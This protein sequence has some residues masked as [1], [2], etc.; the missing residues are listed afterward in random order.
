MI[1]DLNTIL[2]DT[3]VLYTKTQN[4][5]WNVVGETFYSLHGLFEEHY[6][7]LAEAVDEIAERIRTC[8]ET[9]PSTLKEFLALTS[10]EE[11]QYQIPANAMVKDLVG[12]HE[13]IIKSLRDAQKAVSDEDPGTEDLIVERLREHEKMLWMLRSHLS[14]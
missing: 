10:L 1:K 9:P 13:K 3:Y 14:S 5:H 12:S 8:G 4:Y 6:E 11:G 2:A 7:H